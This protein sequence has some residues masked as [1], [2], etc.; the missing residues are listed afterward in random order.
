MPELPDVLDHLGKTPRELG[1]VHVFV[2]A[3]TR[4]EDGFATAV[5]WLQAAHLPMQP[6]TLRALATSV[7]IPE[8][9]DGRVVKGLV[10]VSVPPGVT[11]VSFEIACAP[12]PNAARVRQAWKLFDTL[13]IPK[14][15][16]MKTYHDDSTTLGGGLLLANALTLP[17][18]MAVVPTGGF[19]ASTGGGL[20]ESTRTTVHKARTLSEG[21]VAAVTAGE[22]RR[23]AQAEWSEVWRPGQPLPAPPPPIA[24]TAPQPQAAP[25][26][27]RRVCAKCGFSGK[28]EDFGSDRFCPT[29]G[30]EWD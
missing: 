8:L 21:F 10:P 12:A 15:S 6:G 7:K 27:G 16:E 1:A 3:V 25:K 26:T 28:R 18:G 22:P 30:D 5:V 19:G 9:A 11:E 23:V 2:E 14:E 24:W 29:C 13:E 17:M 20:A 4:A